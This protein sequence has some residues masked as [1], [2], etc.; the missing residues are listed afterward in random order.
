MP[1]F[2]D[3]FTNSSIVNGFFVYLTTWTDA[4]GL[5][6]EPDQLT[7]AGLVFDEFQLKLLAAFTL[8]LLINLLLLFGAWKYYGRDIY[9]RFIKLCK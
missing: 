8:L 6:S 2:V 3:Y 1:S 5:F 7:V 9:D 4:V